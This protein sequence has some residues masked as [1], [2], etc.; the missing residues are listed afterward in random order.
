M[1]FSLTNKT[2]QLDLPPTNK[3]PTSAVMPPI[4]VPSFDQPT[5]MPREEY[6]GL[7]HTKIAVE[8]ELDG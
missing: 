5:G 1:N 2:P 6:L 3:G 7:L 4:P 8:S